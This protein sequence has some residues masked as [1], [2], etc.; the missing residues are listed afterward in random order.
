MAREIIELESLALDELGRVV[1]P[2]GFIDTVVFD[3][4]I[5]TAGANPDCGYSTNGSCSNGTCGN[6]ANTWCTN[7]FACQGSSNTTSCR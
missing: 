4:N 1:L 2:D 3:Q 6:S 7:S 5:M